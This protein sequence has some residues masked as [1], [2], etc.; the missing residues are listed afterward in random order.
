M[1]KD[2]VLTAVGLA[3]FAIENLA[4]SAVHVQRGAAVQVPGSATTYPEVTTDVKVVSVMW[5]YK[6]IDGE[7][8]LA[9]DLKW[10]VFPETGRPVPKPNDVFRVGSSEYRVINNSKIMAGDTLALSQ[11]HVRP[12]SVIT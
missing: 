6:E 11:L 7:R 2:T 9:T 12:N 1:L 8:V 10:L 5:D 4:F 3:K